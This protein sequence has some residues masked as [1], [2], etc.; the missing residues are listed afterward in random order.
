MQQSLRQMPEGLYESPIGLC[1][2]TR[3]M[4]GSIIYR[5][6]IC[7]GIYADY[8]DKCNF[9]PFGKFMAERLMNGWYVCIRLLSD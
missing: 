5:I 1:M 9:Q 3:G 6:C 7:G 2:K 8:F 4:M